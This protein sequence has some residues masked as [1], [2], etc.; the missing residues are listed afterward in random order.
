[1]ARA[2]VVRKRLNQLDEYL[3]I[4]HKLQ[5]YDFEAFINDPEH[6]GSAERFLQLCIEIVIDLFFDLHSTLKPR[7]RL[8]NTVGRG[9]DGETHVALP[10]WPEERPRRDGDT[11]LIEQR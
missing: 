5:Q 3:S 1:M 2:E 7:H 8:A 4:L 11:S 9:R 10:R 6:Y